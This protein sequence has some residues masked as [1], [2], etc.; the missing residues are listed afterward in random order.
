M[1]ITIIALVC[2]LTGLAC[3]TAFSQGFT[4][5]KFI[6]GGTLDGNMA[7]NDAYGTYFADPSN[8][9]MVWGKGI[10]IYG[11]YGLGVRKNNRLT[12]SLGFNNMQNDNNNTV[13][14][15]KFSMTP[16]YTDFRIWTLGAGYEYAFNARCRNKQFIGA[17]IT[18]NMITSGPGSINEFDYS[19][20]MGFQVVGGYEFTLGKKQQTGLMVGVKYHV[21]N[22]GFQQNGVAT[23]ND[24]TGQPGAGFWRR[25]GILSLNLGFNFYTDVKP[26]RQK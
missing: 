24:G 15:I 17:A 8:Y 19:F 20:R 3:S 9:G 12:L 13:P 1:R 4:P 6:I 10:T 25:I 23:L 11:K 2:L 7:T 22:I 5:P 21:P 18:A 16:P 14:F 26:Y